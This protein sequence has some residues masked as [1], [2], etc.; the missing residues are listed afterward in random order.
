MEFVLTVLCL[1]VILIS[2]FMGLF[3]YVF[4]LVNKLEKR[5]NKV[6]MQNMMLK[7]RIMTGINQL[8]VYFA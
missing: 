4:C 2:I 6:E 7:T 3:S 5:V 8:G 1:T